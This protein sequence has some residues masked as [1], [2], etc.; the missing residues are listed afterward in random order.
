MKLGLLA[1][2]TAAVLLLG[3]APDAH[4]AS[5]YV[6]EVFAS[7][8][9]TSDIPYGEAIDEFG[10]PETLLLDLYEPAGDVLP[11]RPVVVFVHGGS[12]TGGNKAT[13]NNVDYVTQLAKRGFVT[14]SISYRLREGGYPPEEQAQV[15]FDGKH[16]AQAA[17]RWFRA[18]AAT[19][20]IDPDRVSIA[21]Y[22]AG[23]VTALFVGYLSE[24]VGDS[25]NPGYP[26][27][28]SAIVDVSGTMGGFADGVIEPGEPPVLIVHGTAD[29]TVPY[30]DATEIVDAVEADGVPYE[31]HTLT[32]VG[33]G[34]FGSLTDD[35]AE[36]SGVF[37]YNHVIADGG[38]GAVGGFTELGAPGTSS[39]GGIL[40]WLYGALA[41]TIALA[42]A[43][44]SVGYARARRAA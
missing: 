13:P 5:R 3:H 30:A 42:S 23:A 31:L 22:S 2:A 41:A 33:H 7:V 21:G 8:D 29:T 4:A 36:W 44:A 40:W 9:V 12:F 19:Y 25:G 1:L 32:G 34:K 18:N 11:E 38:G 28:V 35:I 10:Q 14:A 39:G 16:D 17:V 20:D 26:S 6:D 24:D 43:L 37:I 15:V 27:E